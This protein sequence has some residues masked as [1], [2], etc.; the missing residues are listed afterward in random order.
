[1]PLKAGA[2]VAAAR[3]STVFASS[4]VLGF[5]LFTHIILE[6]L[7]GIHHLAET[8]VNL[9]FHVIVIPIGLTHIRI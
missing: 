2:G 6:P 8:Q 5:W 7:F 4:T 9:F 1:M 3:F